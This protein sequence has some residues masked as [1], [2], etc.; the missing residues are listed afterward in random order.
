MKLMDYH[1]GK[2]HYHCTTSSTHAASTS[3]PTLISILILVIM[4]VFNGI[5]NINL[6]EYQIACDINNEIICKNGHY[7]SYVYLTRCTFIFFFFL[8][9]FA[10]RP[11]TVVFIIF[12]IRGSVGLIPN[13]APP[14]VLLTETLVTNI[15]CIN[16][17]AQRMD[18]ISGVL[19]PNT[20]KLEREEGRRCFGYYNFIDG[21]IM[22]SVVAAVA[23]NNNW[24][25]QYYF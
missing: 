14:P 5:F 24:I 20:V 19:P 21:L 1:N 12:L 18:I 23:T 8:L 16:S 22:L 10:T 4:I 7:M 6:C 15:G 25:F 11:L 3:R 13:P 2:N 17:G 9:R